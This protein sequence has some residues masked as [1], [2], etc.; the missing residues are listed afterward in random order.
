MFGYWSFS[1]AWSFFRMTL[2]RNIKHQT[3]RAASHTLDIW[4]LELLWCLV[5]FP[6]DAPKKHQAPNF[7]ASL[8]PRAGTIRQGQRTAM[9]FRNLPAERETN[10]RSTRLRGKEGNE[11]VRW[12][13]DPGAGVAHENFHAVRHVAPACRDPSF[14]F[15]RSFGGV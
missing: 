11:Q 3:L 9:R 5:L 15:Q 6:H 8:A 14:G 4:L 12:V 10:S 13:H 2:Q 1:G 7:N